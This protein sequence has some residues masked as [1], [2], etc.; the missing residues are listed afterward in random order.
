LKL[1]LLSGG[2][3]MTPTMAMSEPAATALRTLERLPAEPLGFALAAS[4]LG[5]LLVAASGKG[6]RAILIGDG[7]D[8]LL[9]DLRRRFPDALLTKGD[10]R[11]ERLAAAVAAYVDNPAAG[12]SIDL[13]PRGT[14]FERT[15]WNA[16]RDIPPGATQSYGRVARRIG[17]PTAARAVARACAANNIAVAVPCHRVVAS[18]GALSGY[19]W[20]VERKR[21]LLE[22]EGA[23]A[24]SRPFPHSPD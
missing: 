15:V 24:P 19:R 9:N 5:R 10:R 20:G 16:L 1:L 23:I 21:A 3:A 14:D 17:R 7:P 13:D 2:E 18:S 6:V 11:A 12:L 8:E 4:S 22:K